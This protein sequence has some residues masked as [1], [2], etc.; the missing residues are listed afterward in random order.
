MTE[1]APFFVSLVL[2]EEKI[3]DHRTECVG[4]AFCFV[5]L[6]QMLGGKEKDKRI[7]LRK[8]AK[9]R[10]LKEVLLSVFMALLQ[11]SVKLLESLNIRCDFHVF[12]PRAQNGNFETTDLCKKHPQF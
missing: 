3:P 10:Q 4:C 8:R 5:A 12:G 9:F 11:P 1:V 2:T 7:L 6:C